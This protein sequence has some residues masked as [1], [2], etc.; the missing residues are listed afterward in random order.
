MNYDEL[1]APA[2][3]LMRPSGIRKFF[4]LA[5]EMPHCI[6]LGVGEPDFKTPWTI[7]DAGIRSLEQGRTRYTANAGIKELRAEICRYL[8]RRMELNYQPSEVL[9]TVGGSEAIDL[10][11]RALVKPGDEVIIPTP[12]WV[13]YSEIVKLVGATPVYVPCAPEEN[14]DLN[15]TGIRSAISSRTKAILINTPN[16]P[17]GAAYS[18]ETL[19]GLAD[20]LRA[21]SAKYGHRI[22][23]ISDEPY[24]EIMFGGQPIQ[25]AAKFYDDTLTCYSFSK[26]LSLP[27]ERIGYVAANPRCEE[28]LYPARYRCRTDRADVRA[29]QP[30]NRPQLPGVT[31]PAGRGRMPGR[32]QRLGRVRNQH[33]AD[34]RR[35]EKAGLYR[36]QTLR[37]L[38]YLPQSAGG[39]RQ[40]VLQKGHEV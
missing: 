13:S 7:R 5:A 37:H 32:N 16:N 36:G 11:I 23:L 29:D 3:K 8:A 19:T 31:D 14:F 21:A 15:L 26:S 27:G 2:A 34:L 40:C 18:A 20:R 17:S 28:G 1:L 33:G 12:C 24:R 38:L 22:F 9:V 25:Y 35:A 4:D 6:S 30:R 39:G 10:T